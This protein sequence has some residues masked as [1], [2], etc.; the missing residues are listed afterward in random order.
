M[1]WAPWT[2][3][4]VL[5]CTVAACAQEAPTPAPQSDSQ[6]SESLPQGAAVSAQELA[7]Q[8]NNP[9]APVT[10]IQ[11][12]DILLPDPSSVNGAINGLQM[13]P[14]VPIGPF[15]S[16]PHAQ[17]MKISIPL[18]LSTPGLAPPTGCVGCPPISTGASGMGD[19]QVFDLL[20]IKASWGRWGFGPALIFPT[21]TEPQLGAG[22][23]QAGPSVAL[24]VTAI[25]NLTAGFV[26][27][28]P[29]SFAGSPN[30]PAV[31]QMI[32]TPTFTFNLKDG[33]FVGMSDYN[34]T[35]NWENGGAATIPIGMQVGKVVRIGKQPVSL[36]IEAGGVAARPAGTPDPG[37]VLGFELSP[38]F[39][40]HL[41]PGQKVKVRGK[42]PERN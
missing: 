32:I 7:N 22:K 30:R 1:S 34:F 39:N 2:L 27:Q 9:A 24:I 23:W 28:N 12:R 31:N 5:L 8:V 36:S 4:V 37:L 11:F 26:I 38:I 33:W 14:V 15:H 6:T 42:A 41:G 3:A 13:Q 10:L 18:A 29:I 17:L 25:K 40:F 21:A 20:S 19:M 16:F 35:W